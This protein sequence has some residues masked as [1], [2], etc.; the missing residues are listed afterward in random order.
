MGKRSEKSPEFYPLWYFS[1]CCL[2]VIWG[3]W[4]NEQGFLDSLVS[5]FCAAQDITNW[6]QYTHYVEK[7]AHFPSLRAFLLQQILLRESKVTHSFLAVGFLSYSLANM[8]ISLHVFPKKVERERLRN[9][10]LHISIASLTKCTDHT[11]WNPLISLS[12]PKNSPR[13]DHLHTTAPLFCK[14]RTNDA[15]SNAKSS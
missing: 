15:K 5:D 10:G 1:L 3:W 2:K 13:T 8:L 11:R 12:P 9:A 7:P 6:N 14:F 4:K